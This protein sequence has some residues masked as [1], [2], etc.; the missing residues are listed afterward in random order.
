MSNIEI[1]DIKIQKESKKPNVDV[2][3]N[4][5]TF[6]NELSLNNISDPVTQAEIRNY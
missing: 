4:F 6:E 5:D 1:K 2:V 3:D